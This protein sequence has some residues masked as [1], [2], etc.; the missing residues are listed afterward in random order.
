MLQRVHW[1][2]LVALMLS[3]VVLAVGPREASAGT[4]FLG[5][6]AGTLALALVIVIAELCAHLVVNSRT[7]LARERRLVQSAAALRAATARLELEATT[8]TLTGLANRRSFADH[9]SV[10][11]S[12][13][14]RYNRPLAVLMLDLDFFKRVNDQHG[15][16]F[17]DLVLSVVA[18]TV[19]ANIRKSDLVARYGGE[20]FVVLLPETAR[21]DALV[22]AEKLRAAIAGQEFTDGIVSMP[23]TLSV[24]VAAVPDNAP[25]EPDELV[26]L[27]DEALYEA[28][29]AGRNRVAAAPT[30]STPRRLTDA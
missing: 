5:L 26:R 25:A 6:S 24:G 28:K 1:P 9:L 18:Q 30:A 17:G 11:F 14:H 27:A 29:C 10:E 15:H 13:A 7:A 8:D 20:E 23:V 19:R 4:G 2:S 21:R 3:F 12:R 16:A 22:V